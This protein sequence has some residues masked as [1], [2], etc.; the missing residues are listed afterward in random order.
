MRNRKTQEANS[1][2]TVS[3][4][5]KLLRLLTYYSHILQ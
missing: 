2:L 1:V 5:V 4:M 3:M